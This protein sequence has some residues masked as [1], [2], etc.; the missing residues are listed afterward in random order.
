GPV[1][2]TVERV[3]LN[4]ARIVD[5][6]IPQL[7]LAADR[8]DL[9]YELREVLGGRAR[10]IRISG[11]TGR[12]AVGPDGLTIPGLSNSE[13]EG[14]ERGIVLP[15]VPANRAFVDE[16]RIELDTP[17]G[18]VVAAGD[19]SMDA[20]VGSPA[21]AALLVT[22]TGEPGRLRLFTDLGLDA[23]APDRFRAS[24]DWSLGGAWSGSEAGL[25]G[26]VSTA[27]TDGMLEGVTA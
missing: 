8:I 16:F 3:D 26:T 6:S 17:Q 10:S 9:A 24:G 27:V 7:G 12:A 11:L 2:F 14:A 20:P 5:L 25:G 21:R 1:H 22:V 19:L 23:E 15:V 18:A 4:A 13:D